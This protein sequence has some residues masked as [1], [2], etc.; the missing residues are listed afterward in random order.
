MLLPALLSASPAP[1]GVSPESRNGWDDWVAT[2]C[3]FLPS[4]PCP[5]P[6]TTDNPDT[7]TTLSPGGTEGDIL[8]NLKINPDTIAI[9]GFSSG[10]YFSTQFHVAF[11][12]KIS[13]VGIF[14]AGPYMSQMPNPYPA[15]IH[16][17]VGQLASQG[18]IDPVENI[19]QDKVY[20]WHGTQDSVVPYSE[21]PM[22][23]SFYNHYLESGNNVQMKLDDNAEHG[24]PSSDQG[25]ECGEMNSPN[26]V[27]NCNYDGAYNVLT[28]TLGSI[29]NKNP[30]ENSDEYDLREFDQSQFIDAQDMGYFGIS[31]DDTGY[32][33]VPDN[34][35]NG[36]VQCH[37]HLHL[38]GCAQT[39]EWIGTGYALETGFLPLAA[40]N[41]V[42]MVFPQIRAN[43]YNMGGCWNMGT[44]NY[45]P[46]DK[47]DHRYA[48]KQAKQMRVVA[49]IV[50]R[51][52]N[53]SML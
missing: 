7:V 9:S 41:N 20:I 25:G 21:A 24:F 45:L 34:C 40:R 38:H 50:E 13:G 49:R 22:A 29:Q 23:K 48:T 3:L 36:S 19:K 5:S 27:N 1:A 32:V 51:V 43:F 31:M 26:Y 35:K 30:G 4:L 17:I 18:M 28:K 12:K 15:N 2:W 8:D 53:I 39:R 37:L 16:E 44:V 42:V 52:A 46:S 11:S 47:E 33:F 6:S 10:G 14:G